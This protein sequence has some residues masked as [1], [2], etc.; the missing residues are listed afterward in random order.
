MVADP[1]SNVPSVASLPIEFDWQC[2][3][4]DGSSCSFV[5]TDTPGQIEVP[6]SDLVEGTYIFVVD[7]TKGTRSASAVTAAVVSTQVDVNFEIVE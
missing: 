2:Q 7:V 1:N 5:V 6:A 4:D 3:L